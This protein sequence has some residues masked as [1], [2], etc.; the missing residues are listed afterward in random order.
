MSMTI[1]P[2]SSSHSLQQSQMSI[3]VMG[4]KHQHVCMRMCVC[5]LQLY[6]QA[7]TKSARPAFL[8]DVEVRA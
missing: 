6:A 3:A 5:V 8:D 7:L 4:F 2:A 1:M